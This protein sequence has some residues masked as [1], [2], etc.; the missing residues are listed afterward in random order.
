M[1]LLPG[2][3][4]SLRLDGL[5]MWANASAEAIIT[6]PRT[7]Q[8]FLGVVGSGT[9]VSS[10]FPEVAVELDGKVAGHLQVGGPQPGEFSIVTEAEAGQRLLRLSFTNDA[11]E[12]DKGEDRN[13]WLDKFFF[14]PAQAGPEKP[15]LLPAGLVK[16]EEGAGFWL[17]DQ[18]AWDGRVRSYDPAARYLSGL[19][20]NLGAA[21]AAGPAATVISAARME[22]SVMLNYRREGSVAYLGS[23]AAIAIKIR[24]SHGGR[25]DFVVN[26]R[27][28]PAR[29][30]YP[31]IRLLL[32]GHPVGER[33]LQQGGW[34]NLAYTGE[35]T[36]G[37]HRLALEFT[38]DVRL[39]D[40]GEDR[41]LWIRHVAISR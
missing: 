32:D 31:A 9:P 14:A 18:V 26:A 3:G 40:K 21:F 34:H 4:A 16:L 23:N 11:W 12:P 33:Q 20:S 29:G 30:E 41:N 22:P 15:L 35:V 7:G 27:G 10:V 24:F 1:R 25:Y 38:N 37:V 36:A 28:T 13:L 6:L 17:I 2:P 39:P 19:L 8:Y 5:Y